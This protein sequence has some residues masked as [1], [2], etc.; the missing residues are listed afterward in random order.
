MSR[1]TSRIAG[2][3]DPKTNS[4]SSVST[5]QARAK[6]ADHLG[7]LGSKEDTVEKHTLVLS[8]KGTGAE[9]ATK[10]FSSSDTSE[11]LVLFRKRILKNGKASVAQKI[12]FQSLE[13]IEQTTNQNALEILKDAILNVTPLVEVKPQRRGGTVFQVPVEV[14]P[15][16]G[17][18]VALSWLTESAR[19][20]GGRGM[21]SKL[22]A[23]ILDA[24]KKTGN[25]FRKKEELHKIAEANKTLSHFRF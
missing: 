20:R 10:L 15:R 8:A 14:S 11:L 9:K 2:T 24:S 16:R 1:H 3:P 6:P 21:V 7:A 23:E 17:T 5:A 19:D 18:L 4:A 22:A 13:S 12:L 25:S